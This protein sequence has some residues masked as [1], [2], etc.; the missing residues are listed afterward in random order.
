MDQ[1]TTWILRLH[2]PLRVW[3]LLCRPSWYDSGGPT[4]RQQQILWLTDGMSL[5]TCDYVIIPAGFQHSILA[6]R[7]GLSAYSIPPCVDRN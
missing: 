5:P 1:F 3:R 4:L 7:A 2:I 6:R